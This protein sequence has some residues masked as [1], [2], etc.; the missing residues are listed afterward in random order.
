M[1]IPLKVL[2]WLRIQ[3]HQPNYR[4]PLRNLQLNHFAKLCHRLAGR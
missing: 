2:A 3:N 4:R 1:V